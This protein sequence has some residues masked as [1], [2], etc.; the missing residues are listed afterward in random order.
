MTRLNS[1]SSPVSVIRGETQPALGWKAGQNV[2][3]ETRWATADP[4]RIPRYATRWATADRERVRRYVADLV[5]LE[6]DVIVAPG[7]AIATL[8]RATRSVPIV[9][10]QV[11]D[12][13]GAGLVKTLTHPGGNIT[14]EWCGLNY[15][16]SI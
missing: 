12:P 9:F 13:V 15:S 10:T 7:N 16:N 1:V 6:L 2:Q 14:G 4:E 3:F 11:S 5:A 8:Q